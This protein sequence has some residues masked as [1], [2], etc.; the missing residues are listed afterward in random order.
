[1]SSLGILLVRIP[2][3]FLFLQENLYVR[4]CA[5]VLAMITDSIE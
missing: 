4:L 3:A 1:M 2:L 5:I